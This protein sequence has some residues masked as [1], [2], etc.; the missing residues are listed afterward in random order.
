VIIT[1]LKWI[2]EEYKTFSIIA[3]KADKS[4]HSMWRQRQSINKHLWYHCFKQRMKYKRAHKGQYIKP[5]PLFH[6][7]WKFKVITLTLHA[8]FV[9]Y[10]VGCRVEHL[11]GSFVQWLLSVNSFCYRTELNCRIGKHTVL[12]AFQTHAPPPPSHTFQPRFDTDSFR[13]GIDTLCSVTMSGKKECFLWSTPFWGRHSCWHCRGPRISRDRHFL[14]QT[15]RRLWGTTHHT[16]A[17]QPLH[18]WVT[19]D[20]VVPSA[21]GST[22]RWRWHIY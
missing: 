5:K 1:F 20:T 16:I 4:I 6:L 8:A 21:L 12:H 13:I 2:R 9:L 14:L 17:T 19:P 22:W 7:T 15:C 11:V 18:S 3:S 10:M